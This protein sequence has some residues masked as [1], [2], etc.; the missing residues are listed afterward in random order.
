M[1]R[2]TIYRKLFNVHQT[3]FWACI[4]RLAYWWNQD[5]ICICSLLSIPAVIWLLHSEFTFSDSE[6]GNCVEKTGSMHTT[7]LPN[8]LTCDKDTCFMAYRT[9]LITSLK[10]WFFSGSITLPLTESYG[11]VGSLSVGKHKLTTFSVKLQQCI[12]IQLYHSLFFTT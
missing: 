9:T 12:R 3:M 4:W 7:Q 6:I 11:E 2:N 1:Y 5:G 10:L 8:H